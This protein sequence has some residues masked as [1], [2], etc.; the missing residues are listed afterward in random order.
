MR[1]GDSGPIYAGLEY[2][3]I[4]QLHDRIYYGKWRSVS[5]T[6]AD[7]DEAWRQLQQYV[8]LLGAEVVPDA[9][10]DFQD[11]LGKATSALARSDP[12]VDGSAEL[13]QAMNAALSYGHRVLNLLLRSCGEANHVTRDFARYYGGADEEET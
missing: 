6:D 10:S 5:A 13:F 12:R 9:P 3:D 7:L 4:R 2:P 11:Y 8:A 1:E